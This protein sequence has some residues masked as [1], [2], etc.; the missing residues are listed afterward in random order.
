MQ[1]IVHIINNIDRGG[2]ETLLLTIIPGVEKQLDVETTVVILE[3]KKE[4]Y[5][6]FKE[7][8]ITIVVVDIIKLNP[9]LQIYY[10]TRKLK[11]INPTIVHTH[12]L[13]GDKVGQIS[14]T[15]AGV[16]HRINTIHSMESPHSLRG[17]FNLKLVSLL[18][19]RVITVSE[20][21]KEYIVNKHYFNKNK[22]ITIYNAPNFSN[23]KRDF[24]N[25]SPSKKIIT[26]GRLHPAKGFD[27]LIMAFKQLSDKKVNI[28]LEIWGEGNLRKEL[29]DKIES[30]NL[31]E[32][33]KLCGLT[34]NVKGKLLAA[35]YYVSSSLYEGLPLSLIEAA[36]VGLPIVATDIPPHREILTKEGN[37]NY[38]VQA[39]SVESLVENIETILQDDYN[40]L[41]TQMIE[42]SKHFTQ[43]K[44]INGYVQVYRGMLD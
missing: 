43:E 9:L 12:L 6:F 29:Q 18:T 19:K 8:N 28:E 31:A 23:T 32:K 11:E 3:N 10:L 21:A 39:N 25:T 41:S 1:K 22:I 38:L 7:K 20:S 13:F 4:L 16:K 27:N 24:W 14:A 36:T 5:P 30:Y 17:Y 42:I 15:L 40:K 26:V 34:S 44:M 33:V 37:Y 35:D 2:A